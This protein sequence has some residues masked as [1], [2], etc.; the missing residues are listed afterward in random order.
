MTWTC[1][2]CTLDNADDSLF[3]CALCETNRGQSA[4]Q[5]PPPKL[6]LSGVT[7]SVQ[8]NLFGKP[9]GA[10]QPAKKKSKK[11]KENSMTQSRPGSNKADSC[12][13]MSYNELEHRC[14]HIMNATF[15]IRKLRNLQP[16]AIECAL[17][18][19]SCIIVMATG[20]GKSL[21]YQLPAVTL[22]GTTVVVSPLI[23]LMVDQ[24]Q[25]LVA[26]GIS[27]AIISSSNTEGQNMDIVE[28]LL[29]YRVRKTKSKTNESSSNNALAPLNLLYVTPEQI[30]TARF[31]DVLKK[32]DTQ[33]RLALIAIDEAHC[34]SQWGHDFRPAYRKLS[35]I[36]DNL[37]DVPVL[38]FTATATPAVIR[39]ITTVLKLQ[40]CPCHVGSFDRPNIFYKVVQKEALDATSLGGAIRHVCEQVRKWHA[41]ADKKNEACAGIVY[42]HKRDD[43]QMIADRI[44][45]DTGLRAVVYHGGMKSDERTRAQQDWTS[46]KVKVAVATVAFGMGIDLC[47]V[48]YVIHWSMAKSIESFYQESGRGG[49]DGKPAMSLL[50]YSRDDASMFQFLAQKQNPK[51][52]NDQGTRRAL[53]NLSLMVDYCTKPTCRRKFLLMHFGELNVKCDKTCDYCVD[54]EGVEKSIGQAATSQKQGTFGARLSDTVWK[55]E[56]DADFADAEFDNFEWPLKAGDLNITCADDDG[57][58]LDTS[59][60]LRKISAADGFVAASATFAKYEAM[61]KKENKLQNSGFVNFRHKVDAGANYGGCVSS[62]ITRVSE[63]LVAEF[64]S[65]KSAFIPTRMD[66]K[67]PSNS[68]EIGKEAEKLRQELSQIRA[69]QAATAMS[70]KTSSRT[71]PPPPPPISFESKKRRR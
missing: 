35:W 24:V 51:T 67:V 59:T 5:R 47:H 33:K 9:V 13:D 7:P 36:R 19:Q 22:G 6:K 50:Y 49:R 56:L 41:R 37:P 20:G 70:A 39:E 16:A 2:V 3:V 65:A 66:S 44:N 1:A 69:D 4:G 11:I 32:L 54:P 15:Q 12:F 10:A 17:R 58:D 23:A 71:A 53:D 61:E 31:Q 68:S 26:K 46:G 42:V 60:D 14:K 64:A 52:G 21:C 28:R 62:N 25:A 18:R 48:R 29:G 30:Q 34:L 8:F 38:A 40:N 63:H 57:E 27:A 55:G 45:K 43:T